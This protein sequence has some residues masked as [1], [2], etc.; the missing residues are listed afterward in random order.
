MEFIDVV[1]KR[2]SIRKFKDDPIP[3]KDLKSMVKHAGMA[4]SVNNSQPWK[5]LAVTNKDKMK[6]MAEAVNSKI[7][8]MMPDVKSEKLK[9]VK[10][11]VEHFSTFFVDAPVIIVVLNEPYEAVVDKAL[12]KLELSH[13]EID[14]L[15]NH[16]NIQT[17][18]GAVEN[19]LL[20]AVNLGYGGCWLTGPLVARDELESILKV[21]A[22]YRIAACVAVGK[23]FEKQKSKEKRPLDEIFK[24]VD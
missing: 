5:F 11:A 7:D 12:E 16:P 14:K 6:K 2:T 3:L 23:P 8:E 17:I 24:L 22:P 20:S 10:K 9:S 15:R 18:G 19:L 13:E 21:K 4:P 1:K